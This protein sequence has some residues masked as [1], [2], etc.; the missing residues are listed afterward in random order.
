MDYVRSRCLIRGHQSALSLEW[1]LHT[2]FTVYTSMHSQA[3]FHYPCTQS[4]VHS[5]KISLYGEQGFLRVNRL[6]SVAPL[7]ALPLHYAAVLSDVGNFRVD[8]RFRPIWS[9]IDDDIT[10]VKISYHILPNKC[11]CLNKHAPTFYFD[12]L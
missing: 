5:K 12:W 8:P 9:S 6:Y 11:A 1:L 3:L 2:G 10:F 7:C 4:S